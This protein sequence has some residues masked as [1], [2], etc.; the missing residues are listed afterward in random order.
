MKK[1][2][3]IIVFIGCAVLYAQENKNLNRKENVD[4]NAKTEIPDTTRIS[5]SN[6]KNQNTY[7]MKL[8]V[9]TKKSEVK[10]KN[11]EQTPVYTRTLEDVERDIENIEKK[12]EWVK[13]NPEEN[14][15]AK[16]EGWYDE[17]NERLEYLYAEREKHLNK[18]K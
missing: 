18:T 9:G 11:T 2:G 17:M 16:E 5:N 13:N 6:D 10:V 8:S 15:K 1:I 4:L 3:I 12:I 7:P 14:K